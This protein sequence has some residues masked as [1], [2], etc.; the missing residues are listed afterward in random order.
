MTGPP[1]AD[2][3]KTVGPADDGK[4]PVGSSIVTCSV[5][6]EDSAAT[7][8]PNPMFIGELPAQF[9]NFHGELPVPPVEVCVTY[10][11]CKLRSS[12][13]ALVRLKLRIYNHFFRTEQDDDGRA[14]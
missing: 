9:V 4:T 10:I 6:C 7:R 11:G 1:I 12:R 14:L 3:E 5:Y 13:E 8:M 2:A